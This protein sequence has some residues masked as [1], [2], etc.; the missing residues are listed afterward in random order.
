MTITIAGSRFVDEQGRTVLLRGVNLGGSTKVPRMPDGATHRHEGFFDHRSVSFVGRPFPLAQADAHF[1]RLR[2]WGVNFL[3]F[4]VTWEAIEHAGPGIYDHDYLDY[5]EAIVRKAGA[6]GLA[7]FI[8]PHQDVWSR[9][10][11]GDGA[12]GWTFDLLGMDPAMFTETGAAIVHQVHGD[13]FPRMVWPTNSTKLA[14]AT[15]F[16][17]FFAGNRFA[18]QTHIQGEP[19][20]EFLQRH[21][22]D[23]VAQVAARLKDMP[24]VIGYD[25][26]NEPLHG[27]IGCQDIARNDSILKIDACP[28]PY[29][30]MLL[31]AGFPQTVDVFALKLSGMQRTGQRVVN[32]AG[33]RIWRNGTE[34]LWRANGV[35]DL[36]PDGAPRLLRP[37]H[38]ARI[39]GRP[40]DFGQ[41]CYRPFAN[42]FAQA[43]RAVQPGALIFVQTETTAR[44][45]HWQAEDASNI[46]YAPHWYDALTMLLKRYYPL[47]GY[48]VPRQK[49]ILGPR[50]IRRNFAAQLADFR[51]QAQER[52]RGA[53]VLLGE[54]GIP[55]DLEG[56]HA[57]H[58]ND[59]RP[60]LAAIDRTMTALEDT[61]MS[62]TWW[63]YT[64]DNTN[65]HGDQWN[66]EDFSIFS[67]D[68]QRDPKQ[69]DSGGRALAAWLRP[70]ARATAG[71]PLAMPF[72]RRR[73]R[74]TFTFRHD[75]RATT[76]TEIFVPAYHYPHGYRVTVTDGNYEVDATQQLLRYR[77]TTE[78]AE[79]TVCITR[80]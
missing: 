65:A 23:A 72:E 51:A 62:F 25:T 18:P 74:F 40:I 56:G 57:F 14:A 60:Q 10:S 20:Q 28:T 4:L 3:R 33:K 21:Y 49:L 43:I 44:A 34:C 59:Y 41:D 80:R 55:L 9:F 78:Q 76:P 15:L 24:H 17:L 70:Y 38:F 47:I 32:P 73:G 63:N 42:R 48:D 27:F 69:I 11:G 37:D 52:L 67:P 8:D 64:A 6:H 22:I 45:P 35:W 36:G 53:P 61:L 31:G 46:V 13:P 58:T 12:P 77:H 26:M 50:A 71:E 79:H 1:A 54:I 16:T 39:D 5:V 19:A 29:Q 7:L 2:A 30:A 66:G 75:L 68:Q